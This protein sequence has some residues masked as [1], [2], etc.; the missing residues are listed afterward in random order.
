MLLKH[1]LAS[2]GLIFVERG[3]RNINDDLSSFSS[4]FLSRIHRISVILDIVV[5]KPDILTNSNSHFYPI[6]NY[7]MKF[8]TGLKIP[9]I[10]KYIIS[11]Q[12]GFMDTVDLLAILCDDR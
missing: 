5:V 11:W 7:R 9:E 12:Q 2:N 3:S 4:K 10:I 6:N 1:I 8:V